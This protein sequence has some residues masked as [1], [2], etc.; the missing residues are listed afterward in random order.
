M[1]KKLGFSQMI[2]HYS[3]QGICARKS[4]AYENSIDEETQYTPTKFGAYGYY[5]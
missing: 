5:R 2:L 1:P 3:L 4:H